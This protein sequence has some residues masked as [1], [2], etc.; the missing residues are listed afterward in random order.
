MSKGGGESSAAQ[1][2]ELV[3]H[4]GGVPVHG[5]EHAGVV[6]AL[7]WPKVMV[8]AWMPL[9]P[10]TREISACVGQ[11]LFGVLWEAAAPSQLAGGRGMALSDSVGIRRNASVSSS[12]VLAPAATTSARLTSP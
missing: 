1:V 2:G 3:V 5:Q 8:P 7:V 9:V 4:V 11:H 12:C 10:M 6:Q